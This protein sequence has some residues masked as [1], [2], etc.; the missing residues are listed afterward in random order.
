LSGGLIFSILKGNFPGFK[1]FIKQSSFYMWS[2]MKIGLISPILL[3]TGL[4]LGV[5]IGLPFIHF[6]PDPFAEN[7]Y[8]YLYGTW[9]I[10]IFLC[11]LPALLVIDI[12]KVETVRI[13]AVNLYASIKASAR[14]ISIDIIKLA[15]LYLL[16]YIIMFLMVIIYWQIQTIFDDPSLFTIILDFLLLQVSIFL[17]IWVRLSRYTI[18]I[19]YLQKI[20]DQE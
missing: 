10:V 7:I 11:L 16:L 6:L 12:I 17:L 2:M 20:E 9:M 8:I 1:V 15:G 14:R 19:G 4:L 3:F 18:L 13:N 5:L